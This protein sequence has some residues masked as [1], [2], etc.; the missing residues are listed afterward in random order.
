MSFPL[1]RFGGPALLLLAGLLLL[2]P[3]PTFGDAEK[4]VRKT[5]GIEKREPWTTS[6]V[7]GSPEPPNPYKLENVYPELKFD[8]PL[9]LSAV[10][11]TKRWVVAERRGKI[12]TFDQDPKKAKKHLLIDVAKAVLG[13]DDPAFAVYGVVPHPQFATNGYV[14]VTYVNDDRQTVADGSKLVRYKVKQADPPELDPKSETLILTWPSG[15]H[16]GGCI[17]FGPDGFL[18]LSTGDGSGIAD[19]LQTGQD[20][21]DLLGSILRIDVDKKDKDGNYAIP[22]DNPFVKEKGARPEVYAY[23]IRQSLEDQLRHRDRRSVGRRGRTGPVGVDLQ[24]P[25]GRQLRLEH[26]RGHASVPARTQA[27]ADAD[28]RSDRRAS[29]LRVPLAHRR[30]RLSRQAPAGAARRL[31]LRR[32]RHRPRLGAALRRQEKKV[33]EHH[34]LAHS[35]IRIVAWGQD[36]DGEVYA[37]DFIGSGIY[38]LVPTPPRPPDAPQFPRK[39][40]ET[41]LFA[42]TKDLKP[43]T[44]LIPYSVN[45]ELWSDGAYKE[46]FMAIPGE[47]KIEYETV[48]LS[49]A[50]AG[51]RCRAGAS[52][53]A[54]CWSR[55]SPW[56]RSRARR[57]APSPGDAAARAELRARHRGGRRPGLARLH[58]CLERRADRRRLLDAKGLD[59]SSRSRTPRPPT[60]SASRR[61]T[62]PAG[63]NARCATRCR[64][65]TPW[66]STRCS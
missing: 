5:T 20:I 18:Y 7:K 44:G 9:E 52:P 60:A 3:S 41:G 62:S 53:T 49:A 11:G 42:S 14:F 55:R 63:P 10:P 23:G 28:P 29:A 66:A 38:R 34:E 21:S 30:L 1:A 24:N 2:P 64:R 43:A 15:G 35:R 13:K 31:R 65:S 27:R 58:L 40:S 17:R 48:D 54:P 50:G 51:C 57:R 61:G 26:P 56:K 32:L 22:P 6:R 45:A 25:E 36:H 16:N 33:T 8:E 39:L 59:R 47:G 19:G 46:R 12:F 4:P 37:L